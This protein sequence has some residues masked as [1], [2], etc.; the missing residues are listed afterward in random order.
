[1]KE[2]CS[3]KGI[4]FSLVVWP[5]FY[6]LDAYP[7]TEVHEIIEAVAQQAGIHYVDLLP[8]FAGKDAEDYWVHPTDFHPNSRAHAEAAAFLYDAIPW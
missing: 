6:Q 2:Y 5:L 7:L 8:V 3:A 1:M 4:A